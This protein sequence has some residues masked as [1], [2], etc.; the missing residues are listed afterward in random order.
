M[1]SLDVSL[2]SRIAAGDRAAFGEFYDRYAPSI[3]GLLIRML[4]DRAEAEDTLQ[5]VFLQVW[6]T[7]VRFDPS[8]AGPKVWLFLIARSRGT[9]RLRRRPPVAGS[10]DDE[11]TVAAGPETHLE[12]KEAAGVVRAALAELSDAQRS[13]ICQA[14]YGGQSYEAVAQKEGVPVGTIKTRIRLGMRRL[15]DMLGHNFEVPG[16]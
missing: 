7:A 12:R 10:V 5:E 14:F 8:R 2:I 3:F 9:D 13:A 1:N 6:R 15:R 16:S 4:H 11:P